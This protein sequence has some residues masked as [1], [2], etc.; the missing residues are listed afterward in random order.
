[1]YYATTDVAFREI[2]V[3]LAA[4]RASG[5]TN[6]IADVASRL[7]IAIFSMYSGERVV[8]YLLMRSF[9]ILSGFYNNMIYSF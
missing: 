6:A 2:A 9:G 4:N 8:M 7:A 3:C 5:L 1:M